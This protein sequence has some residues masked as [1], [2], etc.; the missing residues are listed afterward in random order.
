VAAQFWKGGG[1]L[2]GWPTLADNQFAVANTDGLVLHQVLEGEG[3][4]EWHG[5]FRTGLVEVRN[6]LCSLDGQ[7]WLLVKALL[8]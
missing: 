7:P 3:T 2:R 6:E 4:T 1:C 5:Q 8:S